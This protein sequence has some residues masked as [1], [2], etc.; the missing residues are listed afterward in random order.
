MEDVR[1]N[2]WNALEEA[3]L[4]EGCSCESLLNRIIDQYLE[5]R[6]SAVLEATMKERRVFS[7]K[8]V[9]IPANVFIILKDREEA[10]QLLGVISDISLTGARIHLHDDETLKKLLEEC[11]DIPVG[12]DF[13]IDMQGD[14]LQFRGETRH[15]RSKDDT[16]EIG[17]AFRKSNNESLDALYRYIHSN[18]KKDENRDQPNSQS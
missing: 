9:L 10:I 7:R 11:G 1:I 13:K 3:A 14:K 8:N 6:K 18:P 17:I 12:L 5:G 4:R 2:N 16:V 15:F